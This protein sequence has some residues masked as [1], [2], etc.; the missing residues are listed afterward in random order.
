MNQ[1]SAFLELFRWGFANVPGI[2]LHYSKELDI[3][4]EDIGV[5][6]AIFYTFERTQPLFQIG[7]QVGQVLQYCPTLSKTKLS[8]RLANLARAEIIHLDGTANFADRVITLEPLLK[9]AE[10]LLLR[11]HVDLYRQSYPAPAPAEEEN[12]VALL[13]DYRSKIEQLELQLEEERSKGPVE[14]QNSIPNGNLK[15]LGDFISKKTGNLMSHKM[16]VEVRKWLEEM[17]FTPEFLLCMLELCFERNI[18]NPGEIT[19]IA[20]DLKEYSISTLEGLES[21]FNNYIDVEKSTRSARTNTFDPEIAGFGN[22]TGIDMSAEARRKVYYKWRY[23]W[24]FSHSMI[25]KAG[26]IMCQR[27]RNG[28]LEYI[29]SVL[30]NWMKKE[31]RQPEQADQEIKNYKARSKNEKPAPAYAKKEKST[32]S[33]TYETFVPPGPKE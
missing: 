30:H 17:K 33:N 14:N 23:D 4:I 20:K 27:T 28:G 29:D 12:K 10:K 9:K 8:R 26:E 7:V 22:Y 11:D 18:Y 6:T 32:V 24:G 31:I 3:E 2:V 25:M 1:H 5:L 16:S 13:D 15:K 19:R 21:Y